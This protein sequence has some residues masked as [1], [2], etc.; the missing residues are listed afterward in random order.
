MP[1]R[2]PALAL[3]GGVIAALVVLPAVPAS[4]FQ[5]VVSLPGYRST[6]QVAVDSPL[7][8]VFVLG[9]DRGAARSGRSGA[10]RGGGRKGVRAPCADWR[11]GLGAGR[12]TWAAEPLRL[13]RLNSREAVMHARG[14][15]YV[16][17]SRPDVRVPFAEVGLTGDLPP[18]R[19]YDTSGDRKSVV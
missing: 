12:G 8:R 3:A 13:V 15:V 2:L 5:P 9:G 1:R 14:K 19:L 17:G 11:A 6:D 7:H 10:G 18:V 4:A 16:E